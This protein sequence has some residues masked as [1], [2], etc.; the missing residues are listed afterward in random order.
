[1]AEIECAGA[2]RISVRALAAS[3]CDGGPQRGN[4]TTLALQHQLGSFSRRF[5]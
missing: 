2:N 5:R 3:V 1:M 4:G